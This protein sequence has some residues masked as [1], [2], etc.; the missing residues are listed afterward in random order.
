MR[1]NT[2]PSRLL[3]L[4]PV[5]FLV[6]CTRI[7]KNNLKMFET[8]EDNLSRANQKMYHDNNVIY[9]SLTDQLAD[10]VTHE[11][12]S[13]WQPKAILIQEYSANTIEFIEN[14]KAELRKESGFDEN[15]VKAVQYVFAKMGNQKALDQ[16]L[17]QYKLD[18]LR[19]DP[20]IQKE[21]SDT[22]V[23]VS[24]TYDSMKIKEDPAGNFFKDIPSIAALALLTQ[25]E[26]NIYSTEEMLLV[27][28][29]NQLRSNIRDENFPTPIVGQSSTYLRNGENIEITAGIGFFSARAKPEIT[30]NGKLIPLN[31]MGYVTYKLPAG[32]PGTHNVPVTLGF[33][34]QDGKKEVR[35]FN[36]KYTVRE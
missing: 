13:V 30:V 36:V 21:F 15:N 7:E 8:L 20:L 31:D 17:Q 35:T 19:L 11:K 28:C 4:L 22:I 33:A 18:L 25:I 26:N 16:R 23:L 3:V 5:L 2:S 1:F 12:A 27:F 9:S 6:S 10:P 14:L 24:R 32:N 29:H 34:D